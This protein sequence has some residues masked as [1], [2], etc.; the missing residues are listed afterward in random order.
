[1]NKNCYII[2]C[3][4]SLALL[5][6]CVKQ[7]DA[8]LP[9]PSVLSI[10]A[11]YTDIE[12]PDTKNAISNLNWQVGWNAGDA[13]AV[14][15]M[16]TGAIAKYTIQ[17]SY[18]GKNYGVFDHAD[19]DAGDGE[20]VAVYPFSAASWEA[21]TLYVTLEDHVVYNAS[22]SYG[23]SEKPAFATN[24][25]Q[26]TAKMSA[27]D[28]SD[29]LGFYRL[30]SL[31][32]VVSN[33]S[34]EQFIGEKVSD[35]VISL[36]GAGR[37]AGKAAVNFDG[38][39]KPSLT[40][41]GGT[42]SAVN[43]KLTSLPKIASA[44]YIV[45]FIPLLPYSTNDGLRFEFLTENYSVG[46][47]RKIK[48]NSIVNNNTNFTLFPG[49]FTKVFSQEDATFDSAWWYTFKKGG[50]DRAGGFSGDGSEMGSTAGGFV[51]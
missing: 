14:V 30:V 38:S 5:G 10:K 12:E 46:F 28:L 36:E 45:R 1:M 8:A 40:R 33:V 11:C 16:G 4:L 50:M 37:I 9:G 24:D 2:G 7:K 35:A 23:G 42:L 17:S 18:V 48:W 25:I 22:G 29:V 3:V 44:N 47:Y 49:G 21:G 31:M 26:V 39:G 13:I 20:L 43:C 51:Q 15:N 32:T 27:S 34:E 41:N 6:A 19:G